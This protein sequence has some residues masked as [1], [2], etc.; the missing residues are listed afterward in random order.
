M[1][2]VGRDHSFGVALLEQMGYASIHMVQAR[3][4]AIAPQVSLKDFI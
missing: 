3:L 1:V 4:S 2:C